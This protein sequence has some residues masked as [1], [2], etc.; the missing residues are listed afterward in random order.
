[1][2]SAKELSFRTK[3]RAMAPSSYNAWQDLLSHDTWSREQ[4]SVLRDRRRLDIARFAAEQSPFYRELY[5]DHGIRPSDLHD[6]EVF[7]SLPFLTK[8]HVRENFER[9]KTPEAASRAAVKSVSSG[10]TGHPLTVLSDRRAP[11]RAYEWRAM[12]W[13]GVD[14]WEN[15]ATIDRSWRHGLRKWQHRIFWW[16]TH[17]SLFHTLSLETE[18]LERFLDT[19][20]RD[21]PQYVVGFI[22][23]VSQV[24]AFAAERGVS[25]A[26]PKAVAVTAGPLLD[27]HRAEMESRFGAPV[28][29]VY[30]STES[31]WLA[32]E[33]AEK[34]GLHVYEDI[35]HLEIIRPD[36]S[37]CDVGEEGETVFTDFS[38]RVFPL[39]RYRIGDRSSYLDGP[40]PC[41][42]PFRRVAGIQGRVVDALVM[43]SGRVLTGDIFDYFEG[44]AHALAQWQVHQS[45]D[46]SVEVTV[47]LTGRPEARAEVEARV[48][49]LRSHVH[50]E[51]PVSMRIVDEL[52]PVRGKFR[53]ITSDVPQ[54]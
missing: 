1:M 22:G 31:N 5:G 44:C 3:S 28:Y 27:G 32:G 14:P 51:V 33:C 49:L 48:A 16:P 10:S 6:P 52:V 39:V 29:T 34:D 12:A 18:T 53:P 47:R 17:K 36:E 21:K 26:P 8:D 25:L 24:A 15:S 41:G 11:V 40:C 30:R 23:G 46:H 35:K 45:A 4:I 54:P 42:R 50:G 37:P 9:I 13:W 43:P 20:K 7:D 19:W 2:P 38:N